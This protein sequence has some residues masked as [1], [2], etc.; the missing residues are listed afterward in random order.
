MQL[1]TLPTFQM[2]G[3]EVEPTRLSWLVYSELDLPMCQPHQEVSLGIEPRILVYETSGFPINLTYHI[4]LHGTR[5]YT[6]AY[7]LSGA[8]RSRTL[9]PNSAKC[10]WEDSDLHK[11]RFKPT[12]F[13]YYATRANVDSETRTQKK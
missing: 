13:T 5:C 2:V 11:V 6:V 7:R 10:S 3:V 8:C 12:A 1:A 9:S 4:G